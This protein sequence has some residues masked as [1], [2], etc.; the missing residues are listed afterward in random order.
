MDTKLG[1]VV[2]LEL[3][4]EVGGGHEV[5]GGVKTLSVVNQ[6]RDGGRSVSTAVQSSEIQRR[7]DDPR[8]ADRALEADG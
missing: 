7:T 8:T 6:D 2:D 5:E 3:T 4:L 1:G